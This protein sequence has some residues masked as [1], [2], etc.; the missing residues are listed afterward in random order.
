MKA[1]KYLCVV[2]HYVLVEKWI[3]YTK[4][5]SGL[6]KEGRTVTKTETTKRIKNKTKKEF[7]KVRKIQ[8]KKKMNLMNGK[9]KMRAS[10]R[11]SLNTGLQEIKGI[12]F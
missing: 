9:K 12:K 10:M 7:N 1:N 6:D 5:S 11:I 2:D 3:P 8:K 4:Q